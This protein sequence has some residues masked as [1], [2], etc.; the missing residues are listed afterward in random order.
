VNIF[1]NKSVI[2]G[3]GVFL[4]IIILTIAVIFY[5]NFLSL[6]SFHPSVKALAGK[7]PFVSAK[8]TES[9]SKK[10]LDMLKETLD[11]EKTRIES[12]WVTI[13]QQMRDI[14]DKKNI[15]D[16]KEQELT[17]LEHQLTGL[18]TQ[19]ETSLKD[20]KDVAQYYELMEPNNAAKILNDLED[21]FIVHLFKN[22]KKESVSRILA[23]LD[24]KKAA[25]VTKKMSGI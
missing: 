3:A 4:V 2:L 23:N 15:L 10:N 20:I 25:S 8:L 19:L 18:K 13:E 11:K 22:M 16:K 6:D 14:E 17:D 12:E 7:I 5:F 1:K 21:D 24:P 9:E